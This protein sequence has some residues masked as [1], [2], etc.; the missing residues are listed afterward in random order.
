MHHVFT[1]F[2]PYSS[3]LINNSLCLSLLFQELRFRHFS[4]KTLFYDMI[5]ASW[6]SHSAKSILLC[7]LFFC[8]PFCLFTASLLTFL[9]AYYFRYFM[10]CIPL[11]ASHYVYIMH[12]II[13]ISCISFSSSSF[14]HLMYILHYIY[15]YL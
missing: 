8:C 4:L 12:L 6:S 10:L 9:N 11:H 14:M 3:Q 13:C 5:Y 7:K 1:S 15:I 2:Y